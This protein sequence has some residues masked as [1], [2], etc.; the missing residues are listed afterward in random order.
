MHNSNE[1]SSNDK[2]QQHTHQGMMDHEDNAMQALKNLVEVRNSEGSPAKGPFSITTY[3]RVR[4]QTNVNGTAYENSLS[5]ENSHEIA[6]Q[7]GKNTSFISL[8][9]HGE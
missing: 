2:C 4:A 1:S 8:G 9:R 3:A 6:R 5:F 7:V